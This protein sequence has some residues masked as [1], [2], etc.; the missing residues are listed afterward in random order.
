MTYVHREDSKRN[1][2]IK[3]ENIRDYN[4]NPTHPSLMRPNSLEF[5]K[6]KINGKRKERIIQYLVTLSFSLSYLEISCNVCL[7]IGKTSEPLHHFSPHIYQNHRVT[8]LISI[9]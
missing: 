7:F 6:R 9:G 3:R 5:N 8:E 1:P 4:S 2:L